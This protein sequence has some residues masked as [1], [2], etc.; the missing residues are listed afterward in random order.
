MSR[1]YVFNDYGGA[2][3]EELMERPV[4][5]PGPGEIL[6]MVF[7]AGVNPVDWKIREGLLGRNPS[8]T[9]PAPMGREVSGVVVATGPEVNDFAVGDEVLGL[10]A[11]GQGGFADHALLRAADA[12]RK[13]AD[14]P[15]AVAATIP[16]A[17]TTAYDLTHAVALDAGQTLVV[18]GA[19]GGVG[20]LVTEIGR[21]RRCK[22]IGI[23]SQAK[24]E[25]VESFGAAFVASGPGAAE[26]VREL[27]PDG[28][29]LIVDLVGG[30]ALRAIAPLAKS[31]DR[32]V[33]AADPEAAQELGG[34]GRAYGRDSL[35]NVTE[36][37]ASGQ[38]TPRI[39]AEYSLDQ[40]RDALAAV[41]GG[42]AL[43]KIVIIPQR[44]GV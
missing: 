29:D 26:A 4:P 23:A 19:G 21:V 41:E 28:V 15:F 9:L 30:D 10:V 1:V 14:L 35:R 22:V 39:A 40:A 11:P 20:H 24:R 34:A 6:V 13:P 42:H 16:V 5:E 18:L 32:I 44:P 33:S 36:L 27:A 12:V 38:I 8:R 25:L 37:I 17:G 43:G 7:A 31:P 2:G 3:T